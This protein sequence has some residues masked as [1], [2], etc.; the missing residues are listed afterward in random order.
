MLNFLEILSSSMKRIMSHLIG[1]KLTNFTVRSFNFIVDSV[2][3][4]KTLNWD[5]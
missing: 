2:F 3:D 1:K 5:T 4:D